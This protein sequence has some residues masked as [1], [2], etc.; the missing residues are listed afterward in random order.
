MELTSNQYST[1]SSLLH[2]SRALITALERSAILDRLVLFGAFAFFI[3]V[4]A[5]IFKKR[6][7]D[8]GVH[9][10]GAVG[11]VV[12]AVSPRAAS[13][14]AAEAV[15]EV[16]ERAGEAVKDEAKGEIARAAAA[17]GALAGAAWRGAEK[18]RE[19]AFPRAEEDAEEDA[20]TLREE[21]EEVAQGVV[22]RRDEGDARVRAEPVQP[23]ASL[24]DDL[25]EAEDDETFFDA[26]EP[27][28]AAPSPAVEP[29]PTPIPEPAPPSAPAPP[30]EPEPEPASQPRLND[31]LSVSAAAPAS[32]D[33][34]TAAAP[35]PAPPSAADAP[36]TIALRQPHPPVPS[37]DA[38]SEVEFVPAAAAGTPAPEDE[39]EG[40]VPVQPASEEGDDSDRV[41]RPLERLRP[42]RPDLDAQ[43]GDVQGV[44]DAHASAGERNA[45]EAVEEEDAVPIVERDAA[46]ELELEH[47]PVAPAEQSLTAPAPSDVP[48]S[49]SKQVVDDQAA[50]EPV[51]LPIDLDAHVDA[52]VLA[53]VDAS[54][55]EARIAEAHAGGEGGT[56]V[57]ER[58]ELR[59]GGLPRVELDDAGAGARGDEG[60]VEEMRLPVDLDKEQTVWERE[61]EEADRSAT[62]AA[63][64]Q[65]DESLLDEMLD[66]QLGSTFGGVV[67]QGGATWNETDAPAAA[68]SPAEAE[69]AEAAERDLHAAAS[70]GAAQLPVDEPAAAYAD[71]PLEE[72]SAALDAGE[73]EGAAEI[74]QE[75]PTPSST[76]TTTAEPTLAAT[77]ATAADEGDGAPSATPEP[78]VSTAPERP[79]ESAGAAVRE[80]DPDEARDEAAPPAAEAEESVGAAQPSSTGVG[81]AETEVEAEAAQT[82]AP[83]SSR[84]D[85]AEEVPMAAE[86]GEEPLEEE[87]E[88]IDE[89]NDAEPEV[90][91]PGEVGEAALGRAE[92]EDVPSVDAPL[93]DAQDDDND[94]DAREI[95]E[96]LP[97]QLVDVEEAGPSDDDDDEPASQGDHELDLE[98]RNLPAHDAED[99]ERLEDLPLS[100]EAPAPSPDEG[101]DDSGEYAVDVDMLD[102]ELANSD[103]VFPDPSIDEDDTSYSAHYDDEGNNVDNNDDGA[104]FES[105]A[106]EAVAQHVGEQ[107]PAPG[108]DADEALHRAEDILDELEHEEEGYGEGAEDGLDAYEGEGEGGEE[109][110]PH[111]QEE[112]EEEEETP[113]PRDEL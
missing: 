2:T 80:D 24:A 62:A 46:L 4:C 98:E 12:G 101:E 27:S 72:A 113:A 26:P 43:L 19:R 13:A 5:H 25:E 56:R 11:S 79:T 67:S 52:D 110:D 71:F 9:V 86:D 65:S 28:V 64:E 105:A 35:P 37:T 45:E 112:E 33:V 6:V 55:A 83:A 10:L 94:G 77:P 111:W 58:E 100:T 39:D 78:P 69:D 89:L 76:A 22:P 53:A 34:P 81:T 102:A 84:Q 48:S 93:P 32:H 50:P 99:T 15:S 92:E 97:I 8:R 36:E 90:D 109:E 74:P 85:E 1:L 96:E 108:H 38:P 88:S 60:Q 18:L 106:D 87:H 70:Q 104:V 57:P 47:D 73:G 16:A 54:A 3:A 42:T 66:A 63:E 95:D 30:R 61:G 20:V 82:L 41:F 23:P 107:A 103:V 17:A 49:S 21:E 31:P 44:V 91:S 59:E 29:T 14:G 40:L 51:T 75:A 68:L 7:I